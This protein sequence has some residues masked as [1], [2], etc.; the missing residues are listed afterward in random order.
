M[1]LS[2]ITSLYVVGAI[3]TIVAILFASPPQW[4]I[5]WYGREIAVGH[6]APN[7]IIPILFGLGVV[8]WAIGYAFVLQQAAKGNLD[9]TEVKRFFIVTLLLCTILTLLPPV[10]SRDIFLYYQ[11]GW[12]ASVKGLNP[13]LTTAASFPNTPGIEMTG[14]FHSNISTPYSPL[15]T[16]FAAWIALASGG[17]L[18]V[19]TILFKL[20]AIGSFIAC[21]FIARSVLRQ[22][23]PQLSDLGFLFVI[24][25][26]LLLIESA[27]SGHNDIVAIAAV[28]LGFMLILKYP[29][30]LWLGFLAIGVGVM[31]KASALPAL[32]VAGLWV[33][34]DIW[35]GKI[36]WIEIPKAI[37]AIVLFCVLVIAPFWTNI[38]DL[39]HLFGINMLSG[40]PYTMWLA[41]ALMFKKAVF[42]IT[43]G[44]GL[45]VT[46][47]AAYMYVSIMLAVI[48]LIC[49]LY[50]SLR[51]TNKEMR[52]YGI[53]PVYVIGTVLQAYWR[54]WYVLWPVTFIALAPRGIWL[55]LIWC[56]SIVTLLSYLLTRSSNVYCCYL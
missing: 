11:H 12:I 43:Q 55:K 18:W 17:S 37:L 46:K 45:D 53:A 9:Q 8:T 32:A 23:N 38:N 29:K 49:T 7:S 6:Q 26:P 13:Y 36:H 27:S 42:H 50:L 51:S 10:L 2:H 1:K 54:Q 47:D 33:C 56:Y 19:G 31:L 40:G 48:T 24:A 34:R 14:E 39:P 22:I 41:P 3:T 20:L 21:A 4:D 28:M 5:F 52:L 25:N 16:H 44:L 15:W 30:Q 35:R